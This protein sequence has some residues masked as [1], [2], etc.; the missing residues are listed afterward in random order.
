MMKQRWM[1]RTLLAVIWA[2]PVVFFGYLTYKYTAIS[3]SYT[4]VWTPQDKAELNIQPLG[5]VSKPFQ[6]VETGE[7]FQRMTGD[8]VY[9]SVEVPRTFETVTATVDL[10]NSGQPLVE[11]GLQNSTEW[12]FD[13]HPLDVPLIEDLDWYTLKDQG[14]VLLQR[15]K[16]FNTIQEFLEQLPLKQGIAEYYVHLDPEYVMDPYISQPSLQI[17][18]PLRGSHTFRGYVQDQP[19]SLDIS[20]VDINRQFDVDTV[21][22]SIIQHDQVVAQA[23]VE[24]DGNIVADGQVSATQNLRLQT[25]EPINGE[26]TIQLSSTDD[27]LVTSID[28]NFGYLV[29]QQL[30]LAGNSEYRDPSASFSTQATTLN[31]NA[32]S[33][34]AVTSHPVGLQTIQIGDMEL[35][36]LKVNSPE[37]VDLPDQSMKTIIVPQNDVL[38]KSFGW[39]SFTP[40]SFFDPDYLIER[41]I[42]TT[43]LD[44]IDF[45]Y[46][47][48]LP[49]HAVTETRRSVTFDLAD[50]PGDKKQLN[51]IISAPGLDQ[52]KAEITISS[53]RLEF[54]RP[55]LT[56][57][58]IFSRLFNRIFS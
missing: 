39:M 28:T 23:V 21:T 54:H 38:L 35:P 50:V 44:Q 41:L 16:Q 1:E 14:N 3:G 34:Q 8:P 51:F 24:D 31:T 30:F 48:D 4:F 55:P 52:R 32:S 19:V 40:S 49:E 17:T 2:A 26:F 56:I 37:H 33:L 11:F 58:G 46:A 57:Q 22:A 6:D 20:F 25:T 42:P 7:V 47:S 10:H 53:I 12:K 45:I 15:E 5:R 27:L 13:L 43:N 36:L 9:L 29:T 18:S